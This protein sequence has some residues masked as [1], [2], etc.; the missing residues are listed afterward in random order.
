MEEINKKSVRVRPKEEMDFKEKQ[1]I[2]KY[3]E[4]KRKLG[5][6]FT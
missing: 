4:E 5:R 2:I 1:T 3:Y 6:K